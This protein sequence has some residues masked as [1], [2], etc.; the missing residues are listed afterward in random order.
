M[1]YTY[2]YHK[3]GNNV[4]TKTTTTDQ[5]GGGLR[6]K[7]TTFSFNSRLRALKKVNS[8]DQKSIHSRPIF[9]TLTY[10]SLFP[11]RHENIKR[12]LDVFFKRLLRLRPGAC[13][14]WRLEYQPK[15]GAPHF[16][17]ILF[18]P[19][20][21]RPIVNIAAFRRWCSRAWYQ[22]NQSD[23]IKNLRAGTEASFI[24]SWKGVLYY[25]SKYI[26]KCNAEHDGDK[27]ADTPG[28]FWGVVNRFQF[29]IYPVEIGID[30]QLFVRLNRVIRKYVASKTRGHNAFRN[31]GTGVFCFL[32]DHTAVSLLHYCAAGGISKHY[33]PRSVSD[34]KN[35][36]PRYANQKI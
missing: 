24:K 3:G 17:I 25:T 34:L 15:R 16:H 23:D 33:N 22:S 8:I 14:F 28:R 5:K 10:P 20:N 36:L 30:R 29:P 11:D 31:N 9:I 32:D 13:A 26:A 2:T 35:L 1:A 6:S 7:I 27:M 21:A 19:K 12:H 18:F 4:S